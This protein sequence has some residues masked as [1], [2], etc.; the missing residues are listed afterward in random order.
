MLGIAVQLIL[1]FVL[2]RYVGKTDMTVLGITP[3]LKRI[4]VFLVFLLIMSLVFNV[5][6]RYLVVGKN[7]R[8]AAAH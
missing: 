8:T 6:A 3:T 1:S 5:V 4:Q 7:S 2:L